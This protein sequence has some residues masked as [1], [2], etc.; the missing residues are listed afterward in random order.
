[1]FE[2]GRF[3]SSALSR[4]VVALG[5]EKSAAAVTPNEKVIGYFE[6]FRAPVFRYL[7]RRTHDAGRAEDP[8]QRDRGAHRLVDRPGLQ[9]D[10][11][12]GR[13][14]RGDGGVLRRI[15]F[16]RRQFFGRSA[17]CGGRSASRQA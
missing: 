11:A 12:A 1:M 5:K 16:D 10:L 15:A 7:L 3:A 6:Q 13:Q 8:G 4:S 9:P 17:G 2:L 14:I